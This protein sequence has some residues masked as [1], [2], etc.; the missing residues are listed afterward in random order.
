MKNFL[1]NIINYLY[2][3]IFHEEISEKAKAFL[4]N[5]SYF[6]FGTVISC[7]FSFIFNILAGRI[8]GPIEYGKFALLNSIAMF[9]YIPMLPGLNTAMVKYVAE[10][11]DFQSQSKIISAAFILIFPLI[12]AS[13]LLYFIFAPQLSK[14]LSISPDFFILSVFFAVLYVLYTM[15]TEIIRAIDRIK[16]LSVLRIVFSVVSL[17]VFLFF[18]FARYFSFKAVAFS[19]LVSYFVV[20]FISLLFYVRKYLKFNFDKFW[21][22]KLAKYSFWAAIGSISFA[23]YSNLDKILINKYLTIDKVGIYEAYQFASINMA[24][25]IFGIF[26]TV[27][28]PAASRHE[29]KKNL[30]KKINKFLPYLI[31]LGIIFIFFCEFVILKLY[32]DKYPFN[33]FWALLLGIACV[34]SSIDSAY[35]WT[36]ASVGER[37]IKTI[38]VAVIIFAL[39]NIV[40]DIILIPIIGIPGAI[41]GI[42]LASLTSI[43]TNLFLGRKYLYQE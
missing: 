23:I 1:Q 6:A 32:G 37:G 41:I 33:P 26:N 17:A 11:D 28:F 39:V 15:S 19:T 21:A 43:T 20:I 18:I 31:P 9:L 8:L 3:L 7:F 27:F 34:C 29:N 12:I 30:F 25:L 10:K 42:I 5:I 16:S 24:A 14:M 13:V 35:A 36:L 22:N 40:A 38:S 2:R 4:K